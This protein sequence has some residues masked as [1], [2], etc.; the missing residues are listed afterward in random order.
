MT[1]G[2]DPL[3]EGQRAARKNIPAKADPYQD[4]SENI[5]C[6]LPDIKASPA[7]RRPTNPRTP[8]S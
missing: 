6:G 2:A 7:R 1:T 5:R 4:G 3:G 8:R